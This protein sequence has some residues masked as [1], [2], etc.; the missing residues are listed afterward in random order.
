M[1]VYG[2][3]NLL[4]LLACTV[5]YL[6]VGGNK[7]N[8]DHTPLCDSAVKLVKQ[9]QPGLSAALGTGLD[10][11]GSHGASARQV[12]P[13]S[14][15]AFTF[16]K[17]I[18][19][20]HLA[21]AVHTH[22]P[23]WRRLMLS[24]STGF[25]TLCRRRNNDELPANVDPNGQSQKIQCAVGDSFGSRKVGLSPFSD[26]LRL[27]TTTTVSVSPPDSRGGSEEGPSAF[28][29]LQVLLLP[30]RSQSGLRRVAQ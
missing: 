9:P 27:Q 19:L 25:P 20:Q 26:P 8:F 11:L 23:S 10:S 17:M 4:S 14:S 6:G 13:L 1:Y 29:G 3:S 30:T 5:P 12:W 21:Q 24:N 28:E 16:C 7:R 22:T 18:K 15:S 2:P